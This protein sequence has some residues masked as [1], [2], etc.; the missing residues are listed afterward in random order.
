MSTLRDLFL[1]D[2][3]VTFLNHGSFGATPRP[4]FEV[5]Q[6]WQRRLEWQPVQ[7]LG[8]DIADYLAS[9]R[10]ALGSYLNAHPDD[11]VYVPNATFGVNVIARSLNLGPDDEVLTT[12]HEYGACDNTWLF[13]SGKKGFRYVR[14]AI[15]LPATTP[16]VL[17][18]QLWQGVT[19]RT[20][21]IY[22]SHI[23][24]PTALTFPVAAICARAR[25]EGILT[26]I[27][28]AHAPGQLPLDMDVIGADFYT[29]NCHKWLCAPKGAAFLY[30]RREQQHLVEPLVV[31]W[32]WGEPRAW[33]YG[34]DF[35]DY[36]QWLGTN[37]MAAYLS[38]AAAIE[39][40][41]AHQ[42]DT[43]RDDCQALVTQ[44]IHR[45]GDLTGLPPA[46]PDDQ[47]FYR[48]LAIAPLPP[49]TDLPAFKKRLYTEHRVE[50][51][52]INWQG[53]QFIRVSIQGYNTQTDVN[54]LLDALRLML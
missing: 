16:E 13:L 48:Q 52:C 35:L 18:E 51:P 29:G 53:Q 9:A 14:Q 33:T 28:G 37:D 20:K 47:G 31:G 40:Q 23:T 22:L 21:V 45:I 19:P 2:P 5:Y 4:V 32:G 24:S 42:W 30:A 36:N 10:Q 54:R 44:A 11:L 15:S 7:F 1:L 41:T 8:T 12:D 26:L 6:E 34:S 25:A 43:V 46:Y 17:L 27:D 50:I 49:I 38:V 3:T 39:F